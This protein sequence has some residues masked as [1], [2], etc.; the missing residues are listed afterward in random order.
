MSMQ[1]QLCK[2]NSTTTIQSGVKDN[3]N[4]TSRLVYN[5][6]SDGSNSGAAMKL[7]N[8]AANCK[9]CIEVKGKLS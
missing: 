8:F 5:S 1:L 6:N 2:K 3:N 4:N 9:I 7:V